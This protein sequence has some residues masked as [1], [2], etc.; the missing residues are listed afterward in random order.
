MVVTLLDI[1]YTDSIYGGGN[2]P[3]MIDFHG[4]PRIPKNS[5][6]TRS[7]ISM[8]RLRAYTGD[9]VK[10]EVFGL[11]SIRSA[12][13]TPN[14]AARYKV[15]GSILAAGSLNNTVTITIIDG[16][17]SAF[18]SLNMSFFAAGDI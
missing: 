2:P 18:G 5:P 6:E 9:A 4:N 14:T 1:D 16:G 13:F 3:L 11:K 10:A 12:L 8:G 7:R 17:T 15:A